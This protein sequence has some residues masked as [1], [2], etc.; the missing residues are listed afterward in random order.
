VTGWE[1]FRARDYIVSE[2]RWTEPDPLG[3][4]GGDANLYR[5]VSD[6]PT[7][8]VDPSGLYKI[9]FSKSW[10]TNSWTPAQKAAVNAQL[11]QFSAM[12]TANIAQVNAFKASLTPCQARAI[13][14]E[15]ND[16]LAILNKM[17]KKL[18]SN[19]KLYLTHSPKPNG[20]SGQHIPGWFNNTIW[21]NDSTTWETSPWIF[22]H[23]LSHD[24]G[25]VDGY[26]Y[27]KFVGPLMSTDPWDP[28]DAAH[29]QNLGDTLFNN[30]VLRDELLNR[31]RVVCSR[32]PVP[33]PATPGYIII[34]PGA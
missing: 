9:D 12:V 26:Y 4:G 10:T 17:A 15:L 1:N 5:Y 27:V 8:A 3:F 24:S 19:T 6:E 23:E 21:L 22:F 2:G 14:S 18:A 30:T 33:Q 20:D 34:G 32:P 25:A 7:N 31:A 29:L 11:T 13:A 16:L 28:N